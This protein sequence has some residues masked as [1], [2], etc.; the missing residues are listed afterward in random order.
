MPLD[1]QSIE[2]RDFPVGRRGYDPEAVDAHLAV[3]AEEVETLRRSSRRRSESL[4][5]SASDQVRSIVEA[6]ESSAGEIQRAAEAE[7]RE[8]R[9]EA[10]RDAER[11]RSLA[12]SEAREH[13]EQVSGATDTMLQRLEAMDAELGSLV[14]SLRTGS[15]RLVADLS[16]LQGNMEELRSAAVGGGRAFDGAAFDA[17]DGELDDDVEASARS[18]DAEGDESSAQARDG[19][20][21]DAAAGG[22]DGSEGARLV[23]LS[24]ALNGTSREETDGYLADNF[25]IADRAALLNEVYARVQ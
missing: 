11:T 17:G 21:G 20:S 5:S 12:A 3:V 10:S 7:A 13:V 23:A 2:K 8:I 19:G 18:A 22:D 6:A 15:N 25:D 1:R 14:E 9:D 24:M 16:L 4:A